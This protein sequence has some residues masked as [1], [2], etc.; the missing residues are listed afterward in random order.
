MKWEDVPSSAN[1]PGKVLEGPDPNATAR[2]PFGAGDRAAEVV[3]EDD[4]WV[5]YRH[6]A[7]KGV[8]TAYPFGFGLS[9]T[10]FRY[11]D[12]KLSSAE[13]GRRADRVGHGHERGERRRGARS[14]SSTCRPR[15]R[16]LPSR[17]SSSGAS[18]RRRR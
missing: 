12:L 3:Y 14:C 7:T 5:G 2:G 4:I 6:Y 13:F 9:Y 15:A 11:S 17:P 18:R 8:K 1:F 16:S 10:R